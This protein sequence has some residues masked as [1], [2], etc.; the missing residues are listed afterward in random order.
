MIDIVIIIGIPSVIFLMMILLFL[1]ITK[2]PSEKEIEKCWR[3]SS[4]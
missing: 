2:G 4:G 1:F 3:E